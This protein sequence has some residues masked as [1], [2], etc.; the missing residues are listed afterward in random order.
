ME[1][2]IEEL[3]TLAR[4]GDQVSDTEAVDLEDLALDCWSH[5]E[6]GEATIVA[7]TDIRIQADKSRLGQLLENL[8][9]NAVNHG[10]G[11]VTIT[12]GMLDDGFY[13]E[14]DG[15]GIPSDDRNQVFEAGYSTAQRGTGF[16]LS[17]VKRVAEAHEWDIQ[18]S[19]SIDGGARFEITDVE[20]VR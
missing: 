15:S 8:M 9:R 12:I 5:I 18:V 10:G 3:L 6:T 14:D 4:E 17:I 19:D 7:D 2:L 11:D 1:T 16:G 13:V 20:F